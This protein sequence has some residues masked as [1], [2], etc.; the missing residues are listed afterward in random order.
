VLGRTV[1]DA[2]TVLTAIA[3]GYN[4]TWVLFFHFFSLTCLGIDEL[5]SFTTADPREEGQ[6]V[7]PA[8]VTDFTESCRIDSLRG[9][10]IGVKYPVDILENLR[11]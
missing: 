9:L 10:R 11:R 4:Q 3:G 1:L 2:A 5:D 8:E 6:N 7:R